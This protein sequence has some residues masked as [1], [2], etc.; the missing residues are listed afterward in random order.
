MSAVIK[1][2]KAKKRGPKVSRGP[3]ADVVRLPL[4]QGDELTALWVWLQANH[5]DWDQHETVGHDPDWRAKL[6][7]ARAKGY[8]ISGVWPT[9]A[10]MRAQVAEWQHQIVQRTRAKERLHLMGAVRLDA[11]EDAF[12][13][14]C[15]QLSLASR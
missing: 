12:E 8:A 5:K 10:T 2:P 4:L 13:F 14:L 15:E 1:L 3:L 11:L 6:P 7:M 9:D